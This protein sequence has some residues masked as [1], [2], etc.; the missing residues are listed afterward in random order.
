MYINAALREWQDHLAL[1]SLYC[2]NRASPT[3]GSNSSS[4][5]PSWKD[6]F[7]EENWG[8]RNGF[9]E[10]DVPHLH[11]LPTES[12]STNQQSVY[13]CLFSTNPTPPKP[14]V[15]STGPPS[16]SPSLPVHLPRQ[17]YNA[18]HTT[19]RQVLDEHSYSKPRPS[20]HSRLSLAFKSRCVCMNAPLRMCI[21]CHRFFHSGC[22]LSNTCQ[23]C[24]KRKEMDTLL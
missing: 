16:S 8:D 10:R 1:G 12:Y 3:N 19:R 4:C 24:V 5:P 14:I 21:I 20:N 17:H 2:S 18:V 7:Y 15:S 11:K 23:C 22:S 6:H 13:D 9:V